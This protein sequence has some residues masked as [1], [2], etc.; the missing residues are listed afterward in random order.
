MRTERLR[1]GDKLLLYT[2]GVD[3]ARFESHLPGTPSLLACA[4]R[5]RSLPIH[6]LVSLLPRELF[7]QT[8]QNDA[9]TL[10]GLEMTG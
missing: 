6:E 3:A 5:H 2:D 7:G 10:L 1:P 4:E 9:L 8:G